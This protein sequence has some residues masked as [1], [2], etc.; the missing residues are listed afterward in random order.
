MKIYRKSK[1]NFWYFRLAIFKQTLQ[2][3][4][5]SLKEGSYLYCVIVNGMP[6]LK[7][8]TAFK[9]LKVL[10]MFAKA[11]ADPTPVPS[12]PGGKNDLPNC[13]AL[14]SCFWYSGS[15][16][17]PAASMQ[18]STASDRTSL[19]IAIINPSRIGR[20]NEQLK[21]QN[22]WPNDNSNHSNQGCQAI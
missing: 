4:L 8:R 6:T 15:C 10:H 1:F 20:L 21:F 9:T 7:L 3:D 17:S 14:I 11:S 12:P 5:N 18:S 22:K 19:K 2:W 16:R 13:A